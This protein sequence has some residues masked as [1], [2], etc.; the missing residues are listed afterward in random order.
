[1]SPEKSHAPQ[2]KKKKADCFF[3]SCAIILYFKQRKEGEGQKRK[4]SCELEEDA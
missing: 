2:K 4:Q 1:M 3:K